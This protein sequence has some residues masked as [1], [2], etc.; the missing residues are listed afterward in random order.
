MISLKKYSFLSNES[1]LSI[2][3]ISSEIVDSAEEV[4]YTTYGLR[5]LDQDGG[6]LYAVT[7]I[8]T[9]QAFVE[10]FIEFCTGS[11][12]RLVHVPDLLEDYMA[13]R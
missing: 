2:E 13:C 10:R 11:D 3:L 1:M 7:D 8:D 5:V 6:I 9:R 12:V 4:R